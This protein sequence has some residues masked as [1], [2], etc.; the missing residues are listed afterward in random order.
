MPREVAAPACF[1][2]QL[3]ACRASV[4]VAL[5]SFKQVGLQTTWTYNHSTTHNRVASTQRND[6][7]LSR[8]I[9]ISIC[10]FFNIPKVTNMSEMM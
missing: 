8:L 1:V 4:F 7:V 3:A 9:N 5:G 2:P 6:A 10:T